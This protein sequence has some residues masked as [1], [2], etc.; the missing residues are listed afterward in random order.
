MNNN[1]IKA[2]YEEFDK[3]LSDFGREINSFNTSMYSKTGQ[4]LE[5]VISIGAEWK[6]NGYTDF[7]NN[8]ENKVHNIQDSLERCN[9]IKQI[10]DEA[11]Y[12]IGLELEKLRE[13]V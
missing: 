7:K 9:Q 1:E 8:M 6:G 3:I 12:E 11:S 4:V 10:L 5:T 2:A 13:K